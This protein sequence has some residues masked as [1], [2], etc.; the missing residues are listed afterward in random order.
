MRGNQIRPQ[1]PGYSGPHWLSVVEVGEV[2][3]NPTGALIARRRVA[4]GDPHLRDVH[5]VERRDRCCS[6]VKSL[7]TAGS[8]SNTIPARFTDPAGI[9]LRRVS[10]VF[11]GYIHRAMPDAVLVSGNEAAKRP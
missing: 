5:Q 9:R 4:A 10:Q 3:S 7:W 1:P 8:G 2:G 6:L 11:A